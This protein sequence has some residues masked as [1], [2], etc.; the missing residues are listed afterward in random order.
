M[1]KGPTACHC[2][3]EGVTVDNE[4]PTKWRKGEDS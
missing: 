1:N 3:R 4:P 2:L